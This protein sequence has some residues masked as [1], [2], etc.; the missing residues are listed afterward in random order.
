MKIIKTIIRTNLFE[1]LL[2]CRN[3]KQESNSQQVGGLVTR[4][5]PGFCLYR[6]VLY[7]KSMPNSTDL[8]KRIFLHVFFWSY[9][10]SISGKNQ[11]FIFQMQHWNIHW[12][13]WLF[14]KLSTLGETHKHFNLG[15][16]RQ[17]FLTSILLYSFFLLKH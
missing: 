3:Q 2:F 11:L 12:Y 5:T 16:L 1:N 7:F 8:Y 9:Y 6:V 14:P 10:N 15:T 17:V 4:N 13:K